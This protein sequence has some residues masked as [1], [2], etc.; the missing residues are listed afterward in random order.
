MTQWF[1][2]RSGLKIPGVPRAESGK[3]IQW[4]V[5]RHNPQEEARRIAADLGPGGIRIVFGWGLGFLPLELAR[6]SSLVLVLEPKELKIPLPDLP[7]GVEVHV[8]DSKKVDEELAAIFRTYTYSFL[9]FPLQYVPLPGYLS[10]FPDLSAQVQKALQN[11][12]LAIGPDLG[13]QS[14]FG[15]RW[16]ENTL[17]NLEWWSP[18]LPSRSLLGPA[19]GNKRS[20]VLG[21]GPSLAEGLALLA[22]NPDTY[23]V[24]AADTVF[25]LLCSPQFRNITKIFVSIDAQWYSNLHGIGLSKA[26][27][28]SNWILDGAIDAGFMR[29]LPRSFPLFGG[30]PVNDVLEMAGLPRTLRFPGFRSAGEGALS[31]GTFLSLQDQRNQSS[32]PEVYGI[33]GG[34]PQYR[35]YAGG[36]YL[37]QWIGK[38]IHRTKTRDTFDFEIMARGDRIKLAYHRGRYEHLDYGK[39]HFFDSS[40]KYPLELEEQ[41]VVDWKG[42]SKRAGQIL[43]SG[44][45][46]SRTFFEYLHRDPVNSSLIP[47]ALY[48]Y[49][50]RENEQSLEESFEINRSFMVSWLKDWLK[51]RGL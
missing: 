11:H 21:A 37:D 18:T 27:S 25:P 40:Q 48:R 14:R 36:T 51:R 7:K 35:A 16:L 17:R 20:M 8:L 39:S 49:K 38:E 44:W 33:D 3:A 23:F 13:V 6:V 2:N 28:E 42:M 4:L 1:T 29:N 5:S 46:S 50:I 31:L 32:D 22:S 41:L 12:N 10:A 19:R 9:F 24:V 26:L 15:N 34:Y 47:G 30:H 45:E 43:L